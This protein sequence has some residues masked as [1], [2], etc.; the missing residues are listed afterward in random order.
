MDAALLDCLLDT[1]WYPEPTGSVQHIQTHISHIFLTDQY[2]YKIKK[3]VDFGFLD[4]TTLEKR[5][6]YCHEELRLNRRLSPD[7]YLDVVP[8]CRTADGSYRLHGDGEVVEG[9][10]LTGHLAVGVPGMAM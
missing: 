7:I 9:A 2:A 8:L 3:P 1:A 6:F 4:F 10:S 5:R